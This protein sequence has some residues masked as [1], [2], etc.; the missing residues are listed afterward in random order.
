MRLWRATVTSSETWHATDIRKQH[1]TLTRT[2]LGT[3]ATALLV[4]VPL[5]LATP[6]MAAPD[7]TRWQGHFVDSTNGIR[8][9]WLTDPSSLTAQTWQL[10][11]PTDE[12]IAAGPMFQGPTAGNSGPIVWTNTGLCIG[13]AGEIT[14]GANAVPVTALPCDGSPAQTW[15]ATSYKGNLTF[16]TTAYP[17][18]D[19]WVSN[20]GLTEQGDPTGRY[21]MNSLALKAIEPAELIVTSP[22]ANEAVDSGEVTVAGT[23]QPGA[24]VSVTDGSGN[25]VS[26]TVDDNGDWRAVITVESGPQDIHITDGTTDVDL[27]VVGTDATEESPIINGAV[28]LGLLTVGGATVALAARRRAASRAV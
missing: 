2:V 18:Q 10:G 19:L 20:Q 13:S 4:G 9:M 3:L 26:V 5:A 24:E 14:A 23:G 15:T 21:T 27:T 16:A 1:M 22:K 11:V 25:T 7:P 8:S 28:A 17:H 12:Q 6:A